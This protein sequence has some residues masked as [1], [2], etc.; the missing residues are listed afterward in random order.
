MQSLTEK[1]AGWIHNTNTA[2]G[3]N[4]QRESCT[5][6]W[7]PDGA[8]HLFQQMCQ[9]SFTGIRSTAT[10]HILLKD[11]ALRNLTQLLRKHFAVAEEHVLLHRVKENFASFFILNFV[12]HDSEEQL[13]VTLMLPREGA[14]FEATQMTATVSQHTLPSSTCSGLQEIP[15]QWM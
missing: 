7:S 8:T 15:C 5:V 13:Q 3:I 11:Q 12:L 4:F 2:G 1:W 10:N 9:E 14:M 6:G